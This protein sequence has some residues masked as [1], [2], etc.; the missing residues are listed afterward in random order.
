MFIE[1]P[2][3][4]RFIAELMAQ[5][6]H[7]DAVANVVVGV[8]NTHRSPPYEHGY[9]HY[10]GLDRSIE[11]LAQAAWHEASRG[12]EPA[13]A[14]GGTLVVA[15]ELYT[16]G[17]HS[18][19]VADLLRE[20]PQ[21]TLVLTDLFGN[22]RKSAD[23]LNW[24]HEQNP[25]A[26]VLVLLQVT[27]W[28][29]CVE[30]ARLVQRLAPRHIVYL[31]HHQDAIAFIGTHACPTARKTLVHHCD[32]NASLGG[33]LADVA[34][35]DFTEELARECSHVL[36]RP[37]RILPL[38]VA[39]QGLKAF[40]ALQDP[41]YSV[42]TSGT[43][44]KFA[45]SGPVALQTLAQTVLSSVGGRFFH[46]GPLDA[47][48]LAE[49]Q[50][51]LAAQGLDPARFV[52]LGSVPSLWQTLLQLDAQ[53]YLGSAPAGG[54]RAAIEAQ[55]CGY[56]VVFYRS[57]VQASTTLRVD[58]VYASKCLGWSTLEELREV[59]LQFPAQ[60]RALC[61]EARALYDGHYSHASFMAALGAMLGETPAPAASPHHRPAQPQPAEA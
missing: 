47:E 59:L 24:V 48:W 44:I 33:T 42:V 8:H 25:N 29:K 49:I 17:G 43:H 37:T 5:G 51:H 21:P 27:L 7:N 18:R 31:Q 58:S 11:Q 1:L 56:P 55:G 54:G 35:V 2:D 23:H 30:L 13:P 12:A 40:A 15:T 41:R 46:I 50:R 32:H 22:Y 3:I 53:L 45:R 38:Y 10:P 52:P 34:H 28:G 60:Q 4:Q 39:D 19:V 36:Q 16:V 57:D 9:M 61:A 20:L 6:R 14:R 26:A